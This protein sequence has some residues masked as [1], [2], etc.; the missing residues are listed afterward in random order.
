MFNRTVLTLGKAEMKMVMNIGRMPSAD[1][2]AVGED[3]AYAPG[4]R[5]ALAAVTVAHHSVGSVFCTRLGNDENG[6]TLINYFDKCR[7]DTRYITRDTEVATG[8]SVKINES[9]GSCRRIVFPGANDRFGREEIE[10][11]FMCYP[12]ALFIQFDL[13]DREIIASTRMALNWRVPVFI[14]AGPRKMELPL[15][16]LE[17]VEILSLNEDEIHYY[18]GVYPGDPERCLKSC[19]ALATKV[20]AKYIVLKLGEKG[21]F[22][23]DG[24]Y[25]DVV[26][27][28]DTTFIDGDGAGDVF[29]ATMTADY[30]RHGDI[31]NACRYANLASA[32][33][34]SREGTFEAI[35][36]AEDV[37]RFANRLGVTLI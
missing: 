11:A 1:Q 20:Q 23:Y 8:F 5:G 26:P 25:Y 12:D 21:C 29:S 30:L 4:G 13:P 16:K 7:V 36:T 17:N 32:V 24:S 22:I 9:G 10:G 33:M 18:T 35:P 3:Y 34:V 28:Y 27:S 31:K 37:K 19:M 2:S 14:D 6:D 15:E